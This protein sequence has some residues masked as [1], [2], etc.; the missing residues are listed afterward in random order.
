[1]DE[2]DSDSSDSEEHQPA[3]HESKRRSFRNNDFKSYEDVE[4]V[5]DDDY[6]IYDEELEDRWSDDKHDT[7]DEEKDSFESPYKKHLRRRSSRLD[8]ELDDED[9]YM[10]EVDAEFE[11]LMRTPNVGSASVSASPQARRLLSGLSMYVSS[12]HKYHLHPLVIVL[13]IPLR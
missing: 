3:K 7:P 10:A 1:M 5:E 4:K 13:F 9:A 2:K 12:A 8:Q 11:A 6:K